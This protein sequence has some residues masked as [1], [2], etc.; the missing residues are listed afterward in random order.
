MDLMANDIIL[1]MEYFYVIF[2]ANYALSFEP[3][4]IILLE[5]LTVS[6]L[7]LRFSLICFLYFFLQQLLLT[8][9]GTILSPVI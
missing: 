1:Q 9:L 2:Y 6:I 5:E 4:E 3:F 7:S 8:V